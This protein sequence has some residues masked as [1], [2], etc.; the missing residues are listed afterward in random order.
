MSKIRK[1]IS[2]LMLLALVLVFNFCSYAI[3]VKKIDIINDSEGPSELVKSVIAKNKKVDELGEIPVM[4]YHAIK[5]RGKNDKVYIGGN[6]DEEG[7]NRTIDAFKQDLEM[8]YVN[9]YRM[10]RLIDYINGVIDVPYGK[11]PI[12]L[13]FD[14]ANITDIH[15]LGKDTNGELI[16]DK[17]CT[18][19]ILEEFKKKYPDF[20]VTATFFIINNNFLQTQYIDDIFKYLISHGYDIG[21]HTLDHGNLEK[22]S[23]FQVMY[24][25]GGMYRYLKEKVG[26]NYVKIVALPKGNPV[27][28]KHPNYKFIINGVVD[29][30][31]YKTEGILKVGWKPNESPFSKKFNPYTI[32]RCRAYDN[33]G[34]VYDIEMVFRLLNKSRYVSDG[35]KNT[36]TIPKS[37]ENELINTKLKVIKY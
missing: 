17:D 33:N 9:G 7:Y 16:L 2:I 12:V 5:N 31:T 20:N 18:V 36:I 32:K 15:V 30:F 3:G 25:V 11:S 28:D 4:M 6:V 34:K 26:D 1:K 37:K 29:D 23:E 22:L 27:D 13:T 24:E 10:I 19:A 14:D 35:D 21:N 8:Y